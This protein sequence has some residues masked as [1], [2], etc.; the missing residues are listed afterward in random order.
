MVN[1]TS[2]E[3]WSQMPITTS[4]V[5]SVDRHIT[6][7]YRCLIGTTAVER[8]RMTFFELCIHEFTFRAFKCSLLL[9]CHEKIDKLST[10]VE[11]D[12]PRQLNVRIFD[13]FVLRVPL[14]APFSC[15]LN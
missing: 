2:Q 6:F 10:Q 12:R 13:L 1:S 15:Q 14:R 7:I 9:V 5:A 11:G 8:Q 3:H 4:A